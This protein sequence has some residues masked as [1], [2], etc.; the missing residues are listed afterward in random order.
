MPSDNVKI[1]NK[2]HE[3]INDKD[4]IFMTLLK[5]TVTLRELQCSFLGI[6]YLRTM[7]DL[8]SKIIE[9]G[10]DLDKVSREIYDLLDKIKI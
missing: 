6:F 8:K 7:S 5:D 2:I 4:R 1:I 9:H 3:K 10:S